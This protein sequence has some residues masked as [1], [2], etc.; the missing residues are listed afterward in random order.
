MTDQGR[1]AYSA[2]GMFGNAKT[3]ILTGESIKYLCAVLNSRLPTWFMSHIG[4]STGMGLIQWQKVTVECIPIPKISAIKQRPF[5]KLV[6]S[7]LKIK[8]T[9]P[10]A[11]I[12][13][14]EEGIDQLVY[15]LYGLTKKEIAAIESEN[16]I[17]NNQILDDC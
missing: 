1:F 2:D 9:N 8:T 11:G 6:D 16:R 13:E 4:V 7:I 12:S 10:D 15:A 5:I 3:F 14:Q 17:M